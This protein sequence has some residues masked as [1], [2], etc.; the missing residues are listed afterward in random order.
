[1]VNMQK[2]Y[3]YYIAL[4]YKRN[5]GS[6]LGLGR[7]Y[8]EDEIYHYL[9]QFWFMNFQEFLDVSKEENRDQLFD[10]LNSIFR[11]HLLN[12]NLDEVASS[13]SRDWEDDYVLDHFDVFSKAI[14]ESFE[15]TSG[16]ED[17]EPGKFT[18][19][20]HEEL[21]KT[22]RDFLRR[23]D[24]SL[25]Y[26]HIYESMVKEDKIIY[27][28]L[29]PEEAIK[30]LREMFHIKDDSYKNF[31]LPIGE[32]DGRVFLH[33]EGTIADFCNLAHE[34]A[35]YVSFYYQPYQNDGDLQE[36]PALFY[37]LLASYYL[38]ETGYTNQDV[39]NCLGDRFHYIRSFY[40]SVSCA[41][42]YLQ[43]F[44]NTHGMITSEGDVQNTIQTIQQFIETHGV[45]AYRKQIEL[46]PNMSNPDKMAKDY[47]DLTNFYLTRDP[48]IIGRRYPY[49]IGFYLACKKLNL[50]FQDPD[51]LLEQMK[52]ITTH[53]ADYGLSD[54]FSNDQDKK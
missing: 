26:L 34:F 1:M 37:E 36:F 18:E 39:S 51:V 42:S 41:N 23:I 31:F 48:D 40:R 19:M 9:N 13:I 44:L 45:D 8:N 49:I 33:R 14:Q 15:L 54:F 21:D 3:E 12:D 22:F 29:L 43:Q 11:Y 27:L 16:Y 24:P 6:F 46:N 10:F 2:V 28:D 7:Q 35:H 17:F 32:D 53:F 20:S 47:C 25:D 38:K 5:Y 50:Y 52:V 30:K 4:F